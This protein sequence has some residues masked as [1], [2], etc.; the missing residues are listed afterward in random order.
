MIR[1]AFP[2][3]MAA[4]ALAVA[5]AAFTAPHVR[6]Q[7]RDTAPTIKVGFDRVFLSGATYTL[8]ESS[9]TT[10]YSNADQMVGNVVYVEYVLFERLG[11]IGEYALVPFTRQFEL[12][13][14][15]SSVVADVSEAAS[16]SMLGANL[17]FNK[18]TGRGLKYFFGLSTGTFSATHKM[19]DTSTGTGLAGSSSAL[20]VP[21]NALRLGVE[22]MLGNAGIRVQYQSLSGELD[23]TTQF[24]GFKQT[25]SYTAAELGIGVLVFF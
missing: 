13:D 24:T 7:A 10:S 14:S 12:E 23:D 15:A 4:T 6:A 11:L 17:Y 18:A 5:I 9:T 25:V 21:V 20:S 19:G 16:V 8:E 2:Q 22:W 3:W 1:G